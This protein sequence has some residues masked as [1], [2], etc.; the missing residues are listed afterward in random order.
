MP[1]PRWTKIYEILCVC[2]VCDT[3]FTAFVPV[4]YSDRVMCTNCFGEMTNGMRQ[5][6]VLEPVERK[7]K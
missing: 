2:P 5:T 4:K 6:D 3:K 7:D 1:E